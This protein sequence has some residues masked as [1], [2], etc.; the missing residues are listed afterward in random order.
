MSIFGVETAIYKLKVNVNLHCTLQNMP[1]LPSPQVRFADNPPSETSE[2][3]TTDTLFSSFSPG[4]NPDVETSQEWQPTPQV[5]EQL[6]SLSNFRRRVDG[7]ISLIRSQLR[8]DVEE[9]SSRTSLYYKHKA[10]Q[11]VETVLEAIAPGN[12]KW[13]FQEVVEGCCSLAVENLPEQA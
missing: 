13:L 8:T 12:S 11:V 2:S 9:I 3:S 1:V 7:R 6:I 10:V 5:K 4:A